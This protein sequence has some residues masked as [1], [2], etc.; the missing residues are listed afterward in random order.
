M[1]PLKLLDMGFP[2]YEGETLRKRVGNSVNGTKV[3]EA[4][5]KRWEK[6]D[7]IDLDS[8][9]RFGSHRDIP[10]VTLVQAA[11]VSLAQKVG[12]KAT[13]KE[14]ALLYVRCQRSLGLFP[15]WLWAQ[16]IFIDEEGS[17][18]TRLNEFKLLTE[19]LK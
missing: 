1:D 9:I 12:R 19:F 13:D 18:T 6:E 4:F 3:L 2:A 10:T 16:K 11:Q 5:T 17:V 7:K 14:R 8:L 15:H